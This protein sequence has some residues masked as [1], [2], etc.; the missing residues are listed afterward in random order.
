VRAATDHAHLQALAPQLTAFWSALD[1]ATE[2]QRELQQGLLRLLQLLTANVSELLGDGSWMRGQ[3]RA[4]AALL[5]GPVSLATIATLERGLREISRRQGMLREGLDQAKEAMKQMVA[6]FIER[7]GALAADTGEYHDRLAGYTRQIEQS[8]NLSELSS[9][10]VH[11]MEDTRGVQENLARSRVELAT[12]RQTVEA[13]QERANRLEAELVQMSDRLQEDQLTQVLNRRGLDRVYDAESARADRHARP[14]SLAMLDIDNFKALNDRLGHQAGDSALVHLTH[15]IR[16]SLRT[17]DVIARYGGEEFVILLP[18]TERDHAV[19]V[20]TRVQ[21][22]LTRRFFLHNHE[23]I[24]ITFSVGV[25]ERVP[26]E[27]QD[28]LISR[29]DRALYQA[30]Q[31]GKNRVIAAEEA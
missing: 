11:V 20:M 19:H 1:T 23:R 4:F 7:L 25:A 13:F 16:E 21:R 27:A 8:E 24:L 2:D 3:L 6:T 17:S 12:A 18:E 10:I 31:L 5:D 22:E 15:S 26:G 14:L 9:L 30:K 29:A 28:D